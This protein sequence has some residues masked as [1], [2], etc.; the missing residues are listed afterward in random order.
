MVIIICIVIFLGIIFSSLMIFAILNLKRET[1][2][3][4]KAVKIY[5]DALKEFE[6]ES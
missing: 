5:E 2:R 4:N 1:K 6:N 3:Y